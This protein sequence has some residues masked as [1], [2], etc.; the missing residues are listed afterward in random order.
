MNDSYL[1]AECVINFFFTTGFLKKSDWKH[2]SK[3]LY[4]PARFYHAEERS[5]I[6]LEVSVLNRRHCVLKSSITVLSSRYALD[7]SHVFSNCAI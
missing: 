7:F 6:T 1:D 2:D 4:Y 3:E 5:T